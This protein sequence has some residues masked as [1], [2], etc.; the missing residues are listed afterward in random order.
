M[1][2]DNPIVRNRMPNMAES[3]RL[4]PPRESLSTFHNWRHI[5]RTANQ[6]AT[7]RNNLS[8]LQSRFPS[9][10]FTSLKSFHP[11]KIYQVPPQY[12]STDGMAAGNSWRTFSVRD[13]FVSYRSKFGANGNQ[14]IITTGSP[15]TQGNYDNVFTVNGTDGIVD[16]IQFGLPP[17]S[18]Y[19]VEAYSSPQMSFPVQLNGYTESDAQGLPIQFVLTDVANAAGGWR[20][21]GIYLKILDDSLLGGTSVNLHARMFDDTCGP[22]PDPDPLIIP[23]GVV[24]AAFNG[25]IYDPAVPSQLLVRQVQFDNL[26]NRYPTTPGPT[27][28]GSA[29]NYRGQWTADSLAGQYFWPSDLVVVEGTPR[30]SYIHKGAAIE[31]SPPPGANWIALS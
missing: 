10:G 31:S 11:F 16:Q 7:L 29:L 15:R 21:A 5:G 3:S 23:L 14:P 1:A 6:A 4:L 24:W 2:F 18:D 30:V 28:F 8:Q 12:C 20:G 25:L 26:T 17:N 22:F 13:G 27:G 9:R 19:Q